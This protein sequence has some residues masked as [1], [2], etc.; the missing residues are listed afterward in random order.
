MTGR[1]REAREE[2][3]I[4]RYLQSPPAM[5]ELDRTVVVQVG[6]VRLSVLT[7]SRS[8]NV[9]L[10]LDSY[11]TLTARFISKRCLVS[12]RG[13]TNRSLRPVRNK[14]TLHRI[15]RGVSLNAQMLRL[16]LSRALVRTP[17]PPF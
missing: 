12:L 4:N 17:L 9:T 15:Q 13:V 14:R 3:E 7:R 16:A 2:E 6:R 1:L 8:R 11:T 5:F 10:I